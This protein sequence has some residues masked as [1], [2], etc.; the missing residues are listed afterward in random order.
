M[1]QFQA[2]LFFYEKVLSVKKHQHTKQKRQQFFTLLEVYALPLLFSIFV[3]FYA[4]NLFVKKKINRFEIVPLTSLCYTTAGFLDLPR[5]G[6][7]VQAVSNIRHGKGWQSG[8]SKWQIQT[9]SCR[10]HHNIATLTS[11]GTFHGMG[12]V[13][14]DSQSTGE[15]GNT[16]RL[17]KL[18]PAGV[19]T[20][21][22][23]IEIVSYEQ[24]S[25]M[26]LA[27]FKSELVSQA[28]SSLSRTCISSSGMATYNVL[29]HSAWFL[30]SSEKLRSNWLVFLQCSTSA[31]ASQKLAS[32]ITFLQIIDLGPSDESCI[33]STLLFIISQAG[34]L[35]V[36]THVLLSTNLSG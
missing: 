29:W 30:S 5:R 27:K 7:P 32:T 8:K 35:S 15:F 10:Q 34:K 4:Q 14:V 1:G 28:A 11:R 22:W 23:G 20:K 2:C 13:C 17:K 36:Q 12:I 24:A 21:H 18:Q 31:V 26:G 9:V 19:F 33:Y 16:P 3:L 6:F 25:F